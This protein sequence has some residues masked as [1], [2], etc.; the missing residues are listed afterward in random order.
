MKKL[1]LILLVLS[2]IIAAL[3]MPQ[4]FVWL[5]I[6]PLG[7]I[8]YGENVPNIYILGWDILGKVKNFISIEG[9]YKL[10][11]FFISYYIFSTLIIALISH[12]KTM[13]YTLALAN[14]II[15]AAFP[16]WLTIYTDSVI[17]NSDGAAKDL[18]IHFGSGL[19]YYLAVLLINLFTFYAIRKKQ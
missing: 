14:L 7:K 11:L 15:L 13:A 3:S 18:V 6:G 1:T 9:G 4:T 16:L 12:K 19:F 17:N 2:A 5:E 8:F 10:Q